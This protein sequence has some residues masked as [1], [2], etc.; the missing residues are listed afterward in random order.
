LVKNVRVFVQRDDDDI[1][2]ITAPKRIADRVALN[3]IIMLRANAVF[4][5]GTIGYRYIIDLPI[6]RAEGSFA[7]VE[8]CVAV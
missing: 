5:H 7:Q 3:E 6:G 4:D 8:L 1:I 2:A